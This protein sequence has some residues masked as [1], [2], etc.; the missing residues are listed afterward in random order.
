MVDRAVDAIT[1][2]AKTGQIGDGK[3]FVSRS[4]RRCA[5]A[6]ARPTQTHSERAL[7]KEYPNRLMHDDKIS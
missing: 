6:P 1:A 5:S 4:T 3:I 7:S 2:A